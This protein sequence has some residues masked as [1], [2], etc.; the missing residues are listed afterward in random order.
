[1]DEGT[2]GVLAYLNF[3]MVLTSR[4]INFDAELSI[5]SGH[6]GEFR[7]VSHSQAAEGSPP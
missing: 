4:S 7:D 2:L 1:M 5:V 6:D 3:M